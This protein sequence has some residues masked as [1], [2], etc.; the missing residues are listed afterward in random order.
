MA[1]TIEQLIQRGKDALDRRDYVAALTDF[2]AALEREPDFA[3]VHHFVGLCLSHLGQ[4][5][6]ALEAFDRAIEV[7]ERYVEAHINRA[8]TLSELG[9]Y[10]EASAAFE[11]AGRFEQE[12]AG[13]F[14]S[15]VAARLANA[16]AA[17]GDLYLAASAA[18]EASAQYTAALGLRPH[19]PDI[20]N[21]LAEALMQLGDLDR[22]EAELRTALEANPRFD[23]ARLNL[24]L[25][26]YRRGRTAEALAEWGRVR[27]ADPD[28][29]R[30]RAF[31]SMV[32]RASAGRSP[33]PPVPAGPAGD[34]EASP[35]A[36]AEDDAAG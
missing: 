16:H 23:A 30:V 15:A 2:R 18:A 34:A 29:P 9:R 14:P 22:A 5:E 19:Y 21:K 17:V 1:A 24:G 26:H 3:D 4:P 27:D 7:N 8:I 20:R 6:A 32:D 33:T 11:R 10:E 25:V 13:R 12:G 28:N 31:F 36:P 35:E